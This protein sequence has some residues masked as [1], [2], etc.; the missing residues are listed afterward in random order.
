MTEPAQ[1]EAPAT[2]EPATSLQRIL[3]DRAREQAERARA[4]PP[5]R[6]LQTAL[7]VVLALAAVFV[8]GFAFNAFLSSMQRAMHVMDEQEK[9]QEAAREAERRKAPIPAYAV[10]ADEKKDE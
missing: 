3:M 6:P 7:A 8:V 10:P 4:K 1:T 9:A 5:R 2:H